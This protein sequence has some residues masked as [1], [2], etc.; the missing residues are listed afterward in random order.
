MMTEHVGYSD[1]VIQ[2]FKSL[3]EEKLIEAE[4]EL[5]TTSGYQ[6]DQRDHVASHQ[7]DFNERSNH[8]QRQA[9]MKEQVRRLKGN[10]KELKAA[11]HRIEQKTFG[12][13]ER[14]GKL[15]DK[16]RLLVMPTARYNINPNDN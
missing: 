14:T 15:I 11:L 9:N 8:F 5:A 12:I 6:E 13:C 1:E 4:E 7:V 16:A 3:L 2:H 10:V